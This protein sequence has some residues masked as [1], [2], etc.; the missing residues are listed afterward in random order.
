M[1]PVIN[2]VLMIVAT[3]EAQPPTIP[4]HGATSE[5]PGSD[6]TVEMRPKPCTN[7]SRMWSV[8]GLIFRFIFVALW[9]KHYPPHRW[10]QT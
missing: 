2:W 3:P 10:F 5:R 6:A 8:F 1:L 7:S 4:A 9:R